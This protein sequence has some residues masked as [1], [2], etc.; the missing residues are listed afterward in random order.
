MEIIK[1]ATPT[2]ELVGQK[3]DG[4]I[5]NDLQGWGFETE[6]SSFTS[7]GGFKITWAD[8][9]TAAD[10]NNALAYFQQGNHLTVA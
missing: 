9:P 3:S 6:V 5:L 8:T 4:A 1:M 2:D 7:L 10:S